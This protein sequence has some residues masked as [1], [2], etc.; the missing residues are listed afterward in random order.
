MKRMN[1][2]AIRGENA[3]DAPTNGVIIYD[4]FALAAKAK[5][6]LDRAAHRTGDIMRWSVTPWRADRLKVPREADAALAEAAEAQL[7]VLAVRQVQSLFSW[8]ADWL[9]R[10][11]RCRR[12]REA[13]L[14]VW[15][16]ENADIRSARATP[17]LSQFAR[18]HGL[19]L[20]SDT[21]A[22]LE[23]TSPM[24]ASDLHKREV[25]LTPTHQHI[26]ERPVRDNY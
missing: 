15:D 20:I 26:L 22:L 5:A 1:A 11:A 9:E 16:G 2:T 7:I 3:F 8:L 14:A 10:W 6:M 19:S 23:G 12:V 18:R 4:T 25:S 13:G 24:F 21:T 17:E